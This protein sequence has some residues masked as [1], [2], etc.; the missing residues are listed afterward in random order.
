M[1]GNRCDRRAEGFSPLAPQYGGGR[2][3]LAVFGMENNANRTG[4]N[5]LTA[6]REA[7]LGGMY[8]AFDDPENPS[9]SNPVASRGARPFS[10]W[11]PDNTT[12]DY[13]SKVAADNPSLYSAPRRELRPLC[14]RQ[15]ARRL[16]SGRLCQR[17]GEASIGAVSEGDN[18]GGAVD[19]NGSNQYLASGRA[20]SFAATSYPTP[21]SRPTPLGGVLGD[22]PRA[23][24][25]RPRR[26]RAEPHP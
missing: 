20:T 5:A 24:P 10:S 16:A 15:C 18:K 11:L 6:P 26:P 17:A 23:S 4:A 25:A 19:L 22:P 1:D 14:G 21:A 12:T 13:Q 9:I 2:S 3:N 8:I 7:A